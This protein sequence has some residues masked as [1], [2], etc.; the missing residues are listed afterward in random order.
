M[1]NR[2]HALF[3]N[4]T[5]NIKRMKAV[6]QAIKIMLEP[7]RQ[8]PEELLIEIG[9]EEFYGPLDPEEYLK[10]EPDV[11]FEGLMHG[12]FSNPFLLGLY[13][14][15][16]S[17]GKVILF[18][19]NL[20]SFFGSLMRKAFRDGLRPKKADY[21]QGADLIAYKTY[22]HELFHYDVDVLKTLF[23]S[24]HDS[25]KEEA[26]AV[27]YAH[28]M[29]SSYERYY[30]KKNMNPAIFRYLMDHAFRY[31]SRGYRDWPYYR[32]DVAFKSGLLTYISPANAPLLGRIGVPVDNLIYSM[33]EKARSDNALEEAVE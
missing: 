31:T 6:R 16:R 32:S 5:T 13:K 33:L 2:L 1:E 7:I 3:G 23:S 21:L 27:A 29:L 18:A 19:N 8:V 22:Y 17:P 25:D 26:L 9:P 24:R 28:R 10:P 12:Y 11:D 15:M 4:T 20:Q 14:P 30:T